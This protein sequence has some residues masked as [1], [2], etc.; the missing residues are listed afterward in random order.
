MDQPTILSNLTSTV[1]SFKLIRVARL[2][3]A[4]S[5]A[6]LGLELTEINPILDDNNSTAEFAVELIESALGKRIL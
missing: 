1:F 2:D 3:A 4:E 6:L 5:G